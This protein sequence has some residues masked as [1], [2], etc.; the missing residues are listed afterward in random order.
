[1]QEIISPLLKQY[2]AYF[3]IINPVGCAF[4]FY[5]I[6]RT[7]PIVE[8]RPLVG[9]ITFFAWTMLIGSYFGGIYLLQFFGISIPV[10]RVAGG[11]IVALVAWD[12]LNSTAVDEKKSLPS[13]AQ[14]RDEIAFFPLTMP[15]TVGPGT[16]S[17]AIALAA[18]APSGKPGDFLKS[19]IVAIIAISLIAMTIYY[20]YSY[21]GRLTKL[22]GKT[23]S[24][25]IE[26]LSGFLLFCIGIQIIWVGARE[27]L[28]S[29]PKT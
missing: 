16:I 14:G 18:E 9:R 28:L 17:V 27:L 13:V 1:M 8:R 7:L 26:R 20:S 12:A 5:T 29:L 25:I 10:L 11:I 23:G 24:D 4:I 21:A 22:L 3:S 2:A 15:L 6:T 19:A